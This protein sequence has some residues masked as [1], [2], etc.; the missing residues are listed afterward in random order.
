MP[1][2]YSKNSMTE[3]SRNETLRQRALEMKRFSINDDALFLNGKK[4]VFIGIVL[5]SNIVPTITFPLSRF[6]SS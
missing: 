6:D 3:S 1:L 4:N 2:V 5:S